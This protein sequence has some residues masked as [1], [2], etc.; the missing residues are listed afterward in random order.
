MLL[1]ILGSVEGC[2][3]SDGGEAVWAMDPQT[4]PRGEGGPVTL[5]E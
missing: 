1:N 5:Q 3:P 2:P 4:F